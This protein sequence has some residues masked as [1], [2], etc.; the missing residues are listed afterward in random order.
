MI[1][2]F[3]SE[4]N[5]YFSDKMKNYFAVIAVLIGSLVSISV[6]LEDDIIKF[7]VEELESEDISILDVVLFLF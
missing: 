4:N 2:Y 1:N 6:A 5:I 7:A 3:L